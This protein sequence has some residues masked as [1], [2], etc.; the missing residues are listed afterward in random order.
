MQHYPAEDE[1]LRADSKVVRR[2]GNVPNTL[3]VLQQLLDKDEQNDLQLSLCSVLPA[4]TSTATRQIQHSL[5]FNIGTG[6]CIYVP[7]HVEPASSYI[8]RSEENKTRTIVNH[9]DLPEMSFEDFR[10]VADSFGEEAWCYHFE[11]GSKLQ[12]CVITLI[13]DVGAHTR[14]HSPM[15]SVSTT[16]LS[17]GPHQC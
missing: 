14:S 7:D 17:T 12:S 13:R 9:N 6:H 1:K 4:A 3:E 5:S 15:R 2:G 8:I 11:V 10:R 16:T